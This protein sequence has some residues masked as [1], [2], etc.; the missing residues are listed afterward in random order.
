MAATMKALRK[1]DAAKGLWIESVP[2]P[3][4]GHGDVLVRVKAAS[5]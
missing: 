1:M 5:M 4:V 2:V 3:E